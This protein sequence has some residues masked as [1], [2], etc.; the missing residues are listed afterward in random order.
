MG[1]GLTWERL[2]ADIASI[3]VIDCHEHTQGPSDAPQYPD[4]IA[5]LTQIY[6]DADLRN[7][8][9]DAEAQ[10][11]ASRT[12]SFE[13]KWPVFARLWPRIEHTGY[14]RVS[15][16]VA[17]D[18]YG[19]PEITRAALERINGKLI[20]ARDPATYW[21][22]L[23]RAGIRCRLVNIWVDVRKILDGSHKLPERDR[24]F[25][26]LPGFHS[27]RD[28][29]GVSS[30]CAMTGRSATSLDEY[31]DACRD[32]FTRLQ[33]RGAIGMKDQSAY[34]R[35]IRYENATRDEAER[36]FNFMMEDPRRS[37]GWPEAKP[38]DDWLFHAFMRIAR[39]LDLPVQLHTGGMFGLRNDIAKNNAVH[40][41]G[42][43]ELHRDVRFSLLH[44]NW[45]YGGEWLYLGKNYPNVALDCCWAHIIDPVRT[46]N[47]LAEAVTAVP[48]GKIL[49]FGGDYGDMPEYA[50]AH[51]EIARDNIAAA[52]ARLVDAG[53]IGM[54]EARNVAADW[55]FNNP[56]RFFRLGFD[57]VHV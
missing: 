24:Y 12:C 29:G 55:L 5:A 9:S 46:Q 23:D 40:L 27:I 47:A 13:E 4:A 6:I 26:G 44:M 49:G 1:T 36:L 22:I 7:A 32:I 35:I 8:G 41:T 42:L 52:L 56:N 14:A 30:I 18:F 34:S 45:P 17:R 31:V 16:R 53:W 48:H 11:L 37:L 33:A 21:G 51:L 3:S 28:F 50:A 57:S 39:D 25:I 19:E 54:D 38:L 43:I 20:D 10:V 2:R 15:K